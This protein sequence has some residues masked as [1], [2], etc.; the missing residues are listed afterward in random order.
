MLYYAIIYYTILYY[1]ILYYTIVHYTILY[2][3]VLYYTILYNTILYC[4]ILYWTVLYCTVLTM[5]SGI[6]FIFKRVMTVTKVQKTGLLCSTHNIRYLSFKTRRFYRR[7]SS[8]WCAWKGNVKA[9]VSEFSSRAAHIV[10][11]V[12][13][14]KLDQVHLRV[15]QFSRI[16]TP[17]AR[18]CHLSLHLRCDI[19]HGSPHITPSVL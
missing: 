2:Y 17:S 15:L 3:T 14:L 5:L 9:R 18:H 8:V 1:T 10:L 12:D 4:T 13:K 6:Q 11:V 7:F 16:C 19:G